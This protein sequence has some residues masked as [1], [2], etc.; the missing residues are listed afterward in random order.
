VIVRP[1]VSFHL[2]VHRVDVAA[3]THGRIVEVFVPLE[4]VVDRAQQ[5]A[6]ADH[7]RERH[8]GVKSSRFRARVGGGSSF[9]TTSV[10][11]SRHCVWVIPSGLNKRSCVNA[12]SDFPLTRWTMMPAQRV[13]GIAV[14]VCR[15]RGKVEHL[16]MLDEIE[17]RH[18]RVHLRSR[19]A[20]LDAEQSP[21]GRASRW[22]A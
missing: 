11:S 14:Q 5:A 10:K 6:V 19:A 18:R 8:V 20:S 13:S 9:L 2:G 4:Q 3:S 7:V 17:R 1:L 12:S 22:Y 16:L 15:S 21:T